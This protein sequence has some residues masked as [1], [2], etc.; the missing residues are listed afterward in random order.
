[1]A[2]EES[3]ECPVTTKGKYVKGLLENIHY[4]KSLEDLKSNIML[5]NE[6]LD[7]PYEKMKN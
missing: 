3:W 4:W 5:I 6:A 1:M 2:Q 7:I